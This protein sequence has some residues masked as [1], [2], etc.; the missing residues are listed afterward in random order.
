MQLNS[1]LMQS[2]SLACCIHSVVVVGLLAGLWCIRSWLYL[3]CL[4]AKTWILFRT[5]ISFQPWVLGFHLPNTP[6]ALCVISECAAITPSSRHICFRLF[7]L[8]DTGHEVQGHISLWTTLQP[9]WSSP[10]APFNV[11]YLLWLILEKRGMSSV[12]LPPCQ[13]QSVSGIPVWQFGIWSFWPF[14][15]M[16]TFTQSISCFTTF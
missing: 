14:T 6:L 12:V 8:K 13:L 7:D 15:L 1:W 2:Q 5:G 16:L 4:S 10:G 9:V 3:S 11:C